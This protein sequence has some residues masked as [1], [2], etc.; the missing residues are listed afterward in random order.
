MYEG[1]SHKIFQ[2]HRITLLETEDEKNQYNHTQEQ[3]QLW[4]HGTL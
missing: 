2:L 3:K 1:K 4:A